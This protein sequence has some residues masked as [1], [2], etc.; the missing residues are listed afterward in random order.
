K[1]IEYTGVH[2]LPGANEWTEQERVFTP[3]PQAA[4][5]TFYITT[6]NLDAEDLVEVS[7]VSLRPVEGKVNLFLVGDSTM[8]EYTALNAPR[9]GWGMRLQPLCSPDVLVVNCA[10]SGRSTKSFQESRSW[11][12]VLAQLRPGDYV[13]IGMGINDNAPKATRPQ[14]HTDTGGEF[15]GNLKRWIGEVRSRDALPVLCT[16]VLWQPNGRSQPSPSLAKYNRAILE[17]ARECG[18]PAIDL[19]ARAFSQ[20]AAMEKPQYDSLYMSHAKD[21]C[22]LTEKGAAFYAE[23]FAN[24]SKELASPFATL[25]K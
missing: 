22:H 13:V 17:V 2:F 12:R 24:L 3:F 1:T 18:C 14:N 15:E 9:E 7:E 20:L 6:G 21:Y 25:F 4:S 5:F 23:L 8:C 19:H 11:E 10:V 16:T